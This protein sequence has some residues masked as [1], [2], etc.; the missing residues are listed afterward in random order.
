MIVDDLRLCHASTIVKWFGY[1]QAQPTEDAQHGRELT[2]S[3][4]LWV[5]CVAP[6]PR[7]DLPTLVGER[8]PADV[9]SLPIL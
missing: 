5:C 9:T 7:I 8:D 1:S 3:S 4:G 6:D 2:P